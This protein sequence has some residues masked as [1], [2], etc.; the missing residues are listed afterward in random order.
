MPCTV[1]DRHHLYMLSR[2]ALLFQTT[3]FAERLREAHDAEE[4][5]DAL[6]E[7]EKEIIKNLK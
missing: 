5:E 1:D 6:R 3:N 4:M 7:C 2:I